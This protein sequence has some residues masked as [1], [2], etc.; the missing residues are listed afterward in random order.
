MAIVLVLQ[1]KKP[2]LRERSDFCRR[3]PPKRQPVF[4]EHSFVYHA[5][6]VLDHDAVLGGA[7]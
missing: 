6:I 2:G 1:K 5:I 7:Y 3:K 4:N